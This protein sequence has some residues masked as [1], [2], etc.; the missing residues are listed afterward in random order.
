[1]LQCLGKRRSKNRQRKPVLSARERL[2]HKGE[3]GVKGF[4]SK[5]FYLDR[6]SEKCQ[7]FETDSEF[8]VWLSNAGTHPGYGQAVNFLDKF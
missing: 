6:V 7:C 5:C 4:V 3:I 1:M 2:F 8:E